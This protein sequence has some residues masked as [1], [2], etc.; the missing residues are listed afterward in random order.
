MDGDCTPHVQKYTFFIEK[1]YVLSILSSSGHHTIY[2]ANLSVSSSWSNFESNF[3]N[4]KNKDTHLCSCMHKHLFCPSYLVADVNI[5]DRSWTVN[6][7]ETNLQQHSI[8]FNVIIVTTKLSQDT[9]QVEQNQQRS[10]QSKQHCNS[11]NEKLPLR[12]IRQ[13]E[14]DSRVGG[15]LPRPCRG[16]RRGGIEERSRRNRQGKRYKQIQ[17]VA[18]TIVVNVEV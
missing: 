7:Y 12:K 3:I 17:V 5:C 9:L 4:L 2:S 6:V 1:S 10:T 8:Q 15:H 18:V 11:G 14:P 13:A 16:E